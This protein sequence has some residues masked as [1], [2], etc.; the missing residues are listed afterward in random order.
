MD[1]EAPQL[2]ADSELAARLFEELD[3]LVAALVREGFAL[4]LPE[5][6]RL[7]R[8]VFQLAANGRLGRTAA[9]LASLSL[10]HI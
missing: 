4:G 5:L 7:R 8:L 2:S 9:E 6:L 3:G 10:I 1:G